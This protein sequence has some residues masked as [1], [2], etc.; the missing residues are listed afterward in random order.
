MGGATGAHALS[1]QSQAGEHYTDVS[2]GL[3]TESTDLYSALNWAYND[4]DG[5]V[6]GLAIGLIIP[7][8]T[9]NISGGG[10][11]LYLSPQKCG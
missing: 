7:S 9:I 11:V 3:G 8:G 5:D 4:N 6:K 10:K 1:I 2:A